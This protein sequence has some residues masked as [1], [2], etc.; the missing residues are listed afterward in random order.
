VIALLAVDALMM[1]D[2]GLRIAMA[3]ALAVADFAAGF[4]SMACCVCLA[5]IVFHF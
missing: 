3:V 2:E 4:F 1:S 5:S